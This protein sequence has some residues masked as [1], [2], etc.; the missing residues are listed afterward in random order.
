MTVSV[1]P[2][3]SYSSVDDRSYTPPCSQRGTGA[4]PPYAGAFSVGDRR[5]SSSSL[6]TSP[7]SSL[8][9]PSSEFPSDAPPRGGL[10]RGVMTPSPLCYAASP[11]DSYSSSTGGGA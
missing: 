5:P 11:S 1:F 6:Q 3:G 10:G 7:A 9:S 8:D 4:H 2:T